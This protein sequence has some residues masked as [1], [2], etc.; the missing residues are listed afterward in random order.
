MDF[1]VASSDIG[2]TIFF[3]FYSGVRCTP[4][5]FYHIVYFS[6]FYQPI[7]SKLIILSS[8]SETFNENTFQI[9]SDVHLEF[10]S[11]S[12]C[13]N[14]KLSAPEPPV[15]S[16]TLCLLGDIGWP[17]GPETD[18]NDYRNYV[19]KQADRFENVIIITGNHEYWSKCSISEVDATIRRIADTAPK[20]NVYFLQRET[21]ELNGIL[22]AGCSLW[23]DVPSQEKGLMLEYMCN[24]YR[25]INVRQKH[26]KEKNINSEKNNSEKNNSDEDD[27]E[28]EDDDD[29]NNNSNNNNT[30]TDD[31]DR[32]SNEC[33]K[34]RWQDCKALHSQN[35]AWLQQIKQQHE[36]S[37]QTSKLV[38]LTHHAPTF[39]RTMIPSERS[40]EILNATNLEHLFGAPLKAWCFGHTHRSSTSVFHNTLITSNQAG[41]FSF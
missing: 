20:K 8:M 28:E 2:Q 26:S 35:V 40:F 4:L 25:R 12:K 7:S 30:N 32:N 31:N 18:A 22:F 19:L 33:R 39:K 34:F 17:C 37:K 24:D 29:D 41:L 3:L 15:L 1:S 6:K 5:N 36:N 11:M 14:A 27:E 16:P 9:I 38:F 21:I 10:Y 13:R 23:T